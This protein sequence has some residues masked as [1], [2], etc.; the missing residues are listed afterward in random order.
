MQVPLGDRSADLSA[1]SKE[2]PD[3]GARTRNVLVSRRTIAECDEQ[4]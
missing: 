2:Q 3:R 4:A 1:S